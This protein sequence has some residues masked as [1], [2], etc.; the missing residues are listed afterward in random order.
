MTR[1][2]DII[3]DFLRGA[4]RATIFFGSVLAAVPVALTRPPPPR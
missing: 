4:G 1:L 2:I 3:L